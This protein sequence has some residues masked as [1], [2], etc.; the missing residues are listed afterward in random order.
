MSK[1]RKHCVAS[2][3]AGVVMLCGLAVPPADAQKI[4]VVPSSQWT[5]QAAP[6]DQVT[7]TEAD[8]SLGIAF[9]VSIAQLDKGWMSR[10]QGMFRLLLKKP[11]TLAKD[12]ER[13][14]FEAAGMEF[15]REG[16][17]NLALLPIIRDASGEL[18]IYQSWAYPH[19]KNGSS[20]W[21]RWMS[22]TFQTSE[23][24]GATQNVMEPEGGDGNGRPDGALTF[25]GFEVRA[26]SGETTRE[27]ML[28]LGTIEM[29]GLMLPADE[30]A[31]LFA[32]SLV[33]EAGQY[34]LAIQVTDRFQGMPIRDWVVPLAFDPVSQQSRRQKI[35]IPLGPDGGYW[36]RYQVTGS[37]GRV[38]AEDSFRKQV[39]GQPKAALP[40]AMDPKLPPHLG[41]L[42]INPARGGNG[43]YKADEPLAITARVFPKGAR[44]LTLTWRVHPYRYENVL[45]A[46]TNALTFTSD[47]GQDVMIPVTRQPGRDAYRMEL[48]VLDG[49][50]VV[51]RQR[52]MV[53]S[54]TDLSKPYATRAG[55]TWDRRKVKQSAYFR[56]SFDGRTARSEDDTIEQF[57]TYLDQASALA[58]NT[59]YAIDTA[60]FEVLPGVY[61]FALLDRMMDLAADY[62][63]AMTIRLSH[64]DSA[65]RFLWQPYSYQ[66]N[67]DGTELHGHPFYGAYAV[68]NEPFLDCW[69]R[70][71]RALHDRY[72]AHPAFQG[73]LV[74]QIGGEMTTLDRPWLGETAGYE[75]C[76]DPAFRQYLQKTV[77]SD[78]AGL[79][80]RWGASY[81]AWDEVKPP[82]PDFSA[83]TRPDLRVAWMDFCRF[84]DELGGSWYRRAVTGIRAYDP[85]RVITI[86]GGHPGLHG[87]VDYF[88]NGG[89]HFLEYSGSLRKAWAEGTG[90]LT[91]P[92]H[93]TRW[94]AYGPWILDISTFV[95]MAEAG[96][97]G[98]NFHLYF[99]EQSQQLLPHFGG[100]YAYDRMEKLKPLWREL[101]TAVVVEP[102]TDVATLLDPLTLFCKHRTTFGARRDDLSRWFALLKTDSISAEP[103]QPDRAAP[104]KLLLPNLLDEVMSLENIT[105]LDRLV[106]G[107]AKMIVAANTGSYSPE[108]GT[109]PFQLLRR[110]GIAPPIGPYVQL[111]AGVEARAVAKG[112]LFDKGAKLPFFTLAQMRK[113]MGDPKL[114]GRFFD[115]P[116][117]WIPETDYFGYYK[118]N[119]VKDGVELARFSS[120]GTAVSLHK[121][122][123]GEVIVFWGVPNY[124]PQYYQGM[125]V[126][127]AAWAGVNDPRRGSPIPH[128]LEARS[129]SLKRNYALFYQDKPGRYVQKL[130]ATPDGEFFLD[131]LV[132]D[133]KLGVFTGQELRE[134]GLPVT[135]EEGYSPLKVIRMMP[136]NQAGDW[137]SWSLFR[138]PAA[139]K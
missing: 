93:P 62:A 66:R 98:L 58:P 131:E 127:A 70:S 87:V 128:A 91:E 53:G 89:S 111:D 9:K 45:E 20:N 50:T 133:Q 5:V 130:P 107:G 6:G 39:E 95:M 125:M 33:K 25:V 99:G 82:M 1:S 75:A 126:R 74:Y 40:P 121:V 138:M 44:T 48:T 36:I 120:G 54:Q 105:T 108:L 114:L 122:G 16:R 10:R 12:R 43:V 29:A 15:E 96:G 101:H 3:A 81:R 77:G 134:Q 109:E 100:R 102:P 18:L 37:D 59:T 31:F 42:M 63:M 46:G 30:P 35:E 67:F 57:R 23:A 2:I 106:R 103:L 124:R 76:N 115:W 73:Y 135:Y 32:D 8:G 72:R 56:V 90:T 41:R 116:F 60:Q 118:D 84:K 51:D 97:G 34:R 119:H 17:Y 88:H 19:L 132:S 129:E 38:V 11:V 27:G 52:Y 79:N 55:R 21:G 65:C 26:L 110:L 4:A 78:L 92:H 7:L 137:G 13:V 61:D 85:D 139:K 86:F 123:Q 64:I 80:K 71:Y 22:R 28:H 24:G 47:A 94:A 49:K 136:R 68:G 83:G 117:K 69:E 104:Y 14:I 112:P 113:E